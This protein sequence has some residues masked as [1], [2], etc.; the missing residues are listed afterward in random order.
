AHEQGLRRFLATGES[1][2]LNR[3][4]EITACRRSGEEFPVELAISPL[5]SG[6]TYAFSAF[7]RDIGERK[8]AEQ[9]A[10]A[11]HDATLV[12]AE[13]PTLAEAAPRL[14][15]VTCETVGWDVGALWQVDAR[16]GVLRCAAIWRR[17]GV[18][19]PEF[20]AVT[21]TAAFAPGVGIPG[22][23]WAQGEPIWIPDAVR[24]TSLPRAPV[25]ARE[26]LHGVF[27]LPVVSRGTVL[28]VLEFFSREVEQ[29]DADLVAMLLGIGSQLGQFSERKRAEVERDRFFSLSLDMLCIAGVDGYFKR[30]NPAFEKTL[31]IGEAELLA[32]PYL[33]FVHPDDRA[34]TV[35]ELG[36][37]AVG[38]HVISF[39]HRFR[40]ADGSYRWL[41]WT[42][43]PLLE[44]GLLYMSARD[45]TERKRAEAEL[46]AAK[47]A[48][49]SANRAK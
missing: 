36:P 28:G 12:V 8:R 43:H 11:Q 22:R 6:E 2:V 17:P 24:D 21:R 3:R 34:L 16:A 7:V 45:V 35:G 47:D 25:A 26:G 44:E 14:L 32:R 1:R 39:E 4:I 48:A 15:Q 5:R 20:E 42:A 19:V 31:G 27:A 30:L 49:E 37:L 18:E 41:A 29:P 10:L 9:R 46:Q 40:C 33:E 38:A 13:A 23:V